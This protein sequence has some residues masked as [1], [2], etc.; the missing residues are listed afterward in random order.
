[1]TADRVAKN[2]QLSWSPF[3]QGPAENKQGT[4][5]RRFAG[6]VMGNVALPCFGPGEMRQVNALRDGGFQRP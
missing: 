3:S 2:I 4:C 6:R 5:G 1:M